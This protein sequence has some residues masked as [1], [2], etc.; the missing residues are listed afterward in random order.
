MSPDSD[1]EEVRGPQVVPPSLPPP[2]SSEL[3][4]S[5]NPLSMSSTST[6][7]PTWQHSPI[8]SLLKA[9]PDMT[10][11]NEEDIE[12]LKQVENACK[13]ALQ[14]FQL[15][16]KLVNHVLTPNAALLKFQ[17]SANL[18][19]EQVLRRRSEFLTTH[20]LNV[21]SVRAE[22]G[23]VV[24]AIAR[25][26]RRVLHLPEVWKGWNPDCSHGNHALLIAVKEEDSSLLFL[27]PKTN[28][29]HTL[30][31]GSTGSGKSVLMQNII[32]AIA[33]TNTPEQARIVL[34]DPKLGVDYFAFEGL[35]HLQGGIIDDQDRAILSLNDLVTEM[36][37]RYVVLRENRVSS[38]FGLN[39]KPNRT[40][41]LPFLWV[42]H[43]EFAEWML[44]EEYAHCGVGHRWPIR[45][46]SAGR[47][48]LVG[49]CG[50]AARCAS[51]ADAITHELRESTRPAG[52][53]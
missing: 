39:A 24:I 16:S 6:L 29:P 21:I 53:W 13:A 15:Q 14:H 48:H 22:P 42:I 23:M 8:G 52:G 32:L 17:G 43:D 4:S 47:R 38:I 5:D 28:A 11:D 7:S 45:G 31:A 12:W 10:P 26:H 30:I 33:C 25:P 19:V 51:D 40:E 46:E 37:R 3:E 50:A 18:T 2:I 9:Y 36:N 41:T 27:S 20:K 35:P 34:I 44:T 1:A 49:V